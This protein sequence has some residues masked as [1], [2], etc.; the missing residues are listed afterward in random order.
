ME[1]LC[2]GF[3][4]QKISS[5]L[6]FSNKLDVNVRKPQFANKAKLE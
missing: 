2:E 3:I 1:I 6:S 5:E 4:L